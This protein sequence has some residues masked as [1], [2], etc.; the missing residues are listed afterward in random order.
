V[1]VG[2]STGG[3]EVTRYIGVLEP[4]VFGQRREVV[5]IVIHVV[6]VGGLARAPVAAPVVR[7]DA[8]TVIQ[9]EHHLRVPVVSRQGPAVGKDDGLTAAPVLVI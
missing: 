5:G 8:I 6:A 9:K 3:G 1:H 4:E 2:H 7:N